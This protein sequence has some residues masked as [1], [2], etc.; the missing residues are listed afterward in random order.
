MRFSY[1]R[2]YANVGFPD[3][4][5]TRKA[6]GNPTMEARQ[7]NTAHQAG[8]TGLGE[9]YYPSITHYPLPTRP[10][11]LPNVNYPNKYG[12]NRTEAT[13]EDI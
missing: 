9:R 10:R 7:D 4:L 12:N 1:R 13:L 11:S 3:G 6:S 2:G 8:L 5:A